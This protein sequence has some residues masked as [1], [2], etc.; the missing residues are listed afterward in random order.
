MSAGCLAVV[1]LFGVTAAPAEAAARPAD[2]QVSFAGTVALD[3][4]SGSVIRT[5]AAADDDPA[6]VMTNGHCL[7]SGMPAAGQV[8]TDQPSSR[9]FTLLD[10]GGNQAGTLQ[11][12]KVVY[13]T[14]TDTDITLY[15]LSSTYA[16][17]RQQ[18]QIDALPLATTHPVQGDNIE[19]V[20]GY[21]QSTYSCTI[22]GFAYEVKEADWTWKD[23][24]RYTPD[25]HVIGGTSGSPVIDTSTGQVVAVNNTTNENG[26]QCTLDNPC[27]VDQNGN[28]TIHQGIGYAEETYL[29]APCVGSGNQ[30]DLT[31]PNCALPKP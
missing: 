9:T 27:E 11:A 24:V 23:S 10:A 15:Q 3:D 22:D 25:C 6:M 2:A 8:I 17:I 21:W 5:P 31:L 12:T 18:Y 13:A 19:V 30:I 16:Q 20:S 14:M 28:V 4:C 29:I 7:E 1:T 26:G